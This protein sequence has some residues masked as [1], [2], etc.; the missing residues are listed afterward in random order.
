MRA[1]DWA[2]VTDCYAEDVRLTSRQL[3]LTY[4]IT[5]RDAQVASLTPLY[6]RPS[7]F[8]YELL[9]VDRDWCVFRFHAYGPGD[10]DAGPWDVARVHVAKMD[11]DERLSILFVYDETDLDRAFT[12]FDELTS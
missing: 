10:V 8:L 3:A 2:A 12:Q 6:D 11:A 4:E 5:G 7:D 9:T 1:R